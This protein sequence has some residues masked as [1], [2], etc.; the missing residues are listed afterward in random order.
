MSIVTIYS[1]SCNGHGCAR[2]IGEER[3]IWLARL[4]ARAAGWGQRMSSDYCPKC[5]AAN[6][7][8]LPALKRK[9]KRTKP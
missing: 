6:G 8:A 2:W 4:T 5:L 7:K 3:T 9:S 1:V